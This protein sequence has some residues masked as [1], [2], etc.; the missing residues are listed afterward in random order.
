[1][2]YYQKLTFNLAS[3][4]EL[5]ISQLVLTRVILECLIL[6]VNVC[7]V[8]VETIKRNFSTWYVC[9]T[10]KRLGFEQIAW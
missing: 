8:I 3:A 6:L 7:R 10:S 5:L 2:F 1:M 9:V 4:E